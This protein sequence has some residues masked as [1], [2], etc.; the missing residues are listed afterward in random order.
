MGGDSI[1]RILVVEFDGQDSIVFD[2]MMKVLERYSC[3]ER[4]QMNVEPVLSFPGFEICPSRR[5][6]YQNRQEI[7]LTAKEY[8]LLV[9]LV[10]NQGRVLTYGQIYREVWGEEAFGSENTT[11][12]CHVRNLRGK[13]HEVLPDATFTIRCIREVGY[14]FEVNSE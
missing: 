2:E 7:R 12:G 10:T 6:V 4:L 13:L 1:G 9:L 11:V 5:K 3:F 14:C 8:D